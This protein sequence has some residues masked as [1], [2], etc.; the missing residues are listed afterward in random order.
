[1]LQVR[2]LLQDTC[3]NLDR[4]NAAMP[5]TRRSVRRTRALAPFSEEEALARLREVESISALAALLSWERTRTQRVLTRWEQDGVI[6]RKP[7]GPGGKTM[8]EA[9][10]GGL[11][12]VRPPAHSPDSLWRS[13]L[14]ALI[15][16]AI[17][18][19]ATALPVMACALLDNGRR[20]FAVL[21][22]IVWLP[23]I[24]LSLMAATGF[25]AGNI[26]DVLAKR[27]TAVTKA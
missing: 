9:V 19:F 12:A 13:A 20:W 2:S 4:S 25:A 21:A 14:Q 10:V 24:A 23:M 18:T 5:W 6:V 3:R 26:T 1:M 22:W 7:G 27:S 16:A 15:G 11:P 8:I 17:Y